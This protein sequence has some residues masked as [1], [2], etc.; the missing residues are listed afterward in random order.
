[1]VPG[2][3]FTRSRFTVPGSRFRVQRRTI[4]NSK[5]QF[6]VCEVTRSS[7]PRTRNETVNDDPQ[8]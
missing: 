5:K 1:V 2:S 6:P 8:P 4:P 3:G 7:E